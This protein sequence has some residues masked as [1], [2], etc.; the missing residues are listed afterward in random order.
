[1]RLI[2]IHIYHEEK[3]GRGGKEW[4]RGGQDTAGRGKME[5]LLLYEAS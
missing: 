5:D 3:K 1:M 2:Y 4:E